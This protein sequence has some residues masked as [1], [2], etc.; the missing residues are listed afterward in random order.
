MKLVDAQALVTKAEKIA[1]RDGFSISV[2]VVDVAGL[3][4]LFS[5]MDGTALGTIDVARGLHIMRARLPGR[6]HH[7]GVHV[8]LE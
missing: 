6:S 5:R 8:T 2:S 3:Q 4:V 1:Q 7:E